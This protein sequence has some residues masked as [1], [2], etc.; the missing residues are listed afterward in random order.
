M[1]NRIVDVHTHPQWEQPFEQMAH[2]LRLADKVGIGRIVVL[3]GNLGF[4][5][6]PIAEQVM[7]I[8][9][10]T[11]RLVDRWPGRLIGF[12]R[13][14][15]GLDDAVVEREVE[16]CIRD[17]NLRGIKLAV[18]PNARSA[19]LDATMHLAQA[20]G[21]PVLHH[22]W[23]KTTCKYE[24]ESDPTD[25]AHLAARFPEVRIVVAHLTAAGMRGVQDIRPY[26]NLAIDTSGSQCFSGI[27]E[28]A[29]SVLGADRILFGSDI[30]GRGFSAQLGRI[31]GASI[32]EADKAK[33]LYGNAERLLG[34]QPPTG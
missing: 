14:N 12:C 9:D 2:V 10:L 28:Y 32:G 18:W 17:G 5:Y 6:Q 25:M 19:E 21:L 20:M 29:V 30:P 15:A 23:Y 8:N 4:G 3:G 1:A 33:V 26:P 16:R 13:L 27:V 22:C 7:A 11:M 31:Y 24:G 34:R